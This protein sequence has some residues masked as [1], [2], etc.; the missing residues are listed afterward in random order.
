MCWSAALGLLGGLGLEEG[1]ELS[2]SG[3]Y[4]ELEGRWA[5]VSLGECRCGG[6]QEREAWEMG[7]E[8]EHGVRIRDGIDALGVF[9]LGMQALGEGSLDAGGD[10]NQCSGGGGQIIEGWNSP[11]LGRL[12]EL[13]SPSVPACDSTP[14]TGGLG[15]VSAH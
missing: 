4:L 7:G 2:K 5:A 3:L 8:S 9:G 11:A 12:L 13:T 14:A 6:V 10:L 1:G 15:F